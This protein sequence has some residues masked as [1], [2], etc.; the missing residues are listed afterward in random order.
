[1]VTWLENV[2]KLKT[3]TKMCELWEIYH[4]QDIESHI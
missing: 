3:F 1:M 4:I 2:Y